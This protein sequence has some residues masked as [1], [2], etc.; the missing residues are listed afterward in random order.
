LDRAATLAVLTLAL[1]TA[2]GPPRQTFDAGQV[3]G[4][5]VQIASDGD[6]DEDASVVRT[7]DGQFRAVWWSKR[8]GQYDLFTRVSD[9]GAT[10]TDEIAITN[11]PEEDYAPSLIQS[12]D[13]TFHLAWFRLVRALARKDIWYARSADG[14]TWSRPVRIST[15]GLDWVPAIYEDSF[16]M[17]WIVWSSGR[18]GNRE[19]YT[20]RSGDGG[21]T[22]SRFIRLTDSPEEDD[23]PAVIS[24]PNGE[25]TLAWTRYAHG[26]KQ[27]DYYR[28]ASAEVV[29]ATSKDGLHW[30]T[31]V[32]QS[33][34]D[35]ERRYIEILPCLFGDKDGRHLYLAWT[36]NRPSLYG[37]ILVRELTAPDSPIRQLTDSSSSD[38]GAR[39]APGGQPGAYLMV[40]SS[41]RAGAPRVFA[42]G[43]LL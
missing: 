3:A 22:W 43:L 39:I 2:C 13:G 9:D 12:R 1:A 10:W 36:S 25:R 34:P 28:D 40:W 4:E 26:S 5:P 19:L 7:R 42:R 30:S 33:P 17:V 18:S 24:L 35:P 21:R 32:T 14:R 6:A 11:D 23:F 38:Y 29:T 31:P 27:D 37:E 41:G 8:N 20:V 15:Q 16:G